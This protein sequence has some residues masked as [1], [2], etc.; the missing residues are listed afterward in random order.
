MWRGFAA[1]YLSALDAVA[2]DE[3]AA[4]DNGW[5]QAQLGVLGQE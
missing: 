1:A 2:R 5:R 3:A 4:A